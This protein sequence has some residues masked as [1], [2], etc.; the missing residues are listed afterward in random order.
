MQLGWLEAA[1]S[2]A[3]RGLRLHP[4]E[5]GLMHL[6][7]RIEAALGASASG[8]QGMKERTAARKAAAPSASNAGASSSSSAAKPPS[9]SYTASGR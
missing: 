3:Q 6:L 5:E 2:A 8:A 4:S 9:S 1:L 7:E